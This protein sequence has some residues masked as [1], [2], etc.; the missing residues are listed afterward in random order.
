MCHSRERG[1]AALLSGVVP[2]L[3]MMASCSLR[4][5]PVKQRTQK[6]EYVGWER[7]SGGKKDAVGM[8]RMQWG[9]E[10]YSRDEKDAVGVK[11]I[12]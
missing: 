9:Q 4:M 2:E 3:A 6:M 10:R 1:Q 5:Q 11:K 7:C 8:R 12:Q